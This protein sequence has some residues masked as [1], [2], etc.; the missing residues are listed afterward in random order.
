MK[1]ASGSRSKTGSLSR[2]E[3]RNAVLGIKAKRAASGSKKASSPAR[4]TSSSLIERYLGHFGVGASSVG[5]KK[6]VSRKVA[7]KKSASKK[8][9]AKSFRRAG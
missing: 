5:A 6:A 7:S 9:T 4:N 2:G 1:S 8:T 3:A